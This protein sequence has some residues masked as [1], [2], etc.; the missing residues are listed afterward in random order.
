VQQAPV[1]AKVF[2]QKATKGTKVFNR[3]SLTLLPSVKTLDV[4]GAASK[5]AR[6][7]PGHTLQA[8]ALVH[9]AWLRLAGGG[10]PQFQNR[11][12][13]FAAAAEAPACWLA[14]SVRPLPKQPAMPPFFTP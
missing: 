13:F 3:S 2:P 6:E 4:G 10:T 1:P 14:F 5:M 7:A 12:H 11:G 9:E 8:T